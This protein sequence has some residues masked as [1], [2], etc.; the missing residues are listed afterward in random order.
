M[1]HNHLNEQKTISS[2]GWTAILLPILSLFFAAASMAQ[3]VAGPDKNPQPR[4]NCP[5]DGTIRNDNGSC[6]AVEAYLSTG[7]NKIYWVSQSTGNDGNPGTKANP[8]KSISRANRAGV[9]RPGDAVV[10]RQGTYR[11]SIA[12]AEA[13]TSGKRITFAA[14]PGERVVVSGAE[15]M[16]GEW[17]QSGNAWR[18][19]WTLP[20]K[21][22][23]PKNQSVAQRP[24]FRREMVIVDGR[25]LKPVFARSAVVPGTFYVEGSDTA[26]KAIYMRLPGDASPSGHNIEVGKRSAL[27]LPKGASENWCG[28]KNGW[29]RVVG[30][31]FR[32]AVN[33]ADWAAVCSG[34]EGSLFEENTIEWTNG[35]AIDIQGRNNVLRGNR[36]NNNGMRGIG[37][38]CRGCRLEYNETSDNN[39]KNHGYGYGSSGI[40][41]I[42]TYSTV[43]SH[44]LSE[45]NNG[46]GIWFDVSNEDNVI[47]KSR[48]SNNVG[49][50]ILLEHETVRTLVKNNVIYG[51]K[52]H[53]NEATGIQT[54]ATSHNTIVH[55]TIIGNEGYGIWIKSNPRAQ[56]GYNKI[57][58][59][60]LVDN[61]TS[62]RPAHSEIRLD[63]ETLSNV[64][65][66]T[67]NGNRYWPH[68]GRAGNT[69]F[70]RTDDGQMYSGNDIQ[71]WRSK[72]GS[73]ASAAM[74]NTNKKQV[75]NQNSPEGWRLVSTSDAIAASTVLPS[76]I[77]VRTDIETQVRPRTAADV[78]ADQYAANADSS[79]P[80]SSEIRTEM[81]S[82]SIAQSDANTWHKVSL[83]HNYG[84][85]VLIVSPVSY[86]GN[87]PST[88]NVRNVTSSG[89]EVQIDEWD[90]LDGAHARETIYY[91]VFEAGRHA[92][93][94]GGELEAGIVT[95]NSNYSRVNFGKSFSSAPL[96]LSQI[97][98]MNE[99]GAAVTRQRNVTAGGFDLVLQGEEAESAH[100]NEKVAY[101]AISKG[102]GKIGSQSFVA[103]T[104]SR[105]V[106]HD[107]NTITFGQSFPS[108]PVF[109]AS[110]QT[111][112]GMD[113]ATLRYRDLTGSSVGI[114]VEEEQSKDNEMQHTTEVVGYLAIESSSD[115]TGSAA[116]LAADIPAQL[117]PKNFELSGNYPNPFNPE[118]T[119]KYALPNEAHVTL[120]VYD[121]L[122]RRVALLVEDVQQAGR[123]EARFNAEGLASGI[124]L[125]RLEADSFVKVSQMILM[126]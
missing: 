10:I 13:G 111:A 34:W 14:Y 64:R 15:L 70:L 67:L 26:P 101:V 107:F 31:T 2:K 54:Q 24:E 68:A 116:H 98:T 96:V 114:M 79:P 78:G 41:L 105:V 103:G 45:R 5:N 112:Y 76:G 52:L 22:D 50:G 86:A 75:A 17:S 108:P 123:H 92:L 49:R 62:G 61:A 23:I 53:P 82:L 93:G 30:L 121:V 16:N 36:A 58:N 57:Y 71:Q 74:V 42:Y 69:F 27:F 100:G 28:A 73:D 40:K 51:T 63:G 99:P 59:N 48:I 43:I 83:K 85:P 72:T 91:V 25:V 35:T 9:L 109:L 125:Y 46:A 56:D 12:P 110:M 38:R 97:V 113:A 118:T 102:Q 95:R 29:Y 60:L 117:R 18:H 126:K 44:H 124:Y 55:N 8:W 47:E 104:T 33:S 90:Y 21:A 4:M 7:T 115:A 106:K 81:G 65:T 66:N 3:P 6:V 87:H 88:V 37:G 77:E 11:E 1:A 39:W 19:T 84:N 20:L 80:S 120:E 122:G 32:Y 119:I 89:F 94:G